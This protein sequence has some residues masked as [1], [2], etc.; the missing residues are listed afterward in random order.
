MTR[1][2]R[3][4][5]TPFYFALRYGHRRV[6]KILLLRAGAA[7]PPETFQRRHTHAS[8]LVDAI[9]KVDGWPQYVHRRRA[10]AA[11]IVKKAVTRD[12]LPDAVNL[13]VAAFVEPPGGSLARPSSGSPP[14]LTT[15]GPP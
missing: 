11:S 4:G 5:S 9:R 6:L 8:V 7:V 3:S 12:A 14:L 10:T 13:E 1:A 2:S 15:R